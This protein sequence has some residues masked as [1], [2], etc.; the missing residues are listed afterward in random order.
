MDDFLNKLRWV[1]GVPVLGSIFLLTG[2]CVFLAFQK[3]SL[4]LQLVFGMMALLFLFLMFITWYILLRKIEVA[5]LDVKP[6]AYDYEVQ[7]SIT[8]QFPTTQKEKW[9]EK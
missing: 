9:R 3:S 6:R 4:G 5:R 7:K 2:Y 8:L 1:V